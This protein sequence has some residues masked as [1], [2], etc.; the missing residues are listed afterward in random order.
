MVQKRYY[1]T[2]AERFDVWHMDKAGEVHHCGTLPKE[3]AKE[4]MDRGNREC[5]FRA[6]T[7]QTELPK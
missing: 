6:K 5:G 1:M 2:D 4:R 3:R 7:K